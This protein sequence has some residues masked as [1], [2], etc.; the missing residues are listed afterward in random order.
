MISILLPTKERLV[1]LKK[2]VASVIAQ[3]CHDWELCISDNC[4]GPEVENWIRQLGDGRIKYFRQPRLVAVTDNWNSAY[5]LSSGDYIL[6]LGDDDLLRKGCLTKLQNIIEKFDKPEGIYYQ[7]LMVKY[8]GVT[9]PESPPEVLRCGVASF[10]EGIDEPFL[11]PR[12]IRYQA[13]HQAFKFRMSYPFNMQLALMRR[14]FIVEKAEDQIFRS[15]YPDYFAMNFLMLEAN[16]VVGVPENLVT[17]GVTKKSFGYF[18]FNGTSAYGYNYLQEQADNPQPTR[19]NNTST[20]QHLESWL[21]AIG[22]V[23][24]AA[25]NTTL[26]PNLKRFRLLTFAQLA[27]DG[28]SG[29]WYIQGDFRKIMHLDNGYL[30]VKWVTAYRILRAFSVLLPSKV[31]KFAKVT[32]HWFKLRIRETS[33]DESMINIYGNGEM[34]LSADKN[35]TFNIEE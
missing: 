11:V 6:M 33:W 7:G 21:D 35:F 9:S 10:L 3:D 17:V 30:L 28:I 31:V 26:T 18:Y 4:S 20:S 5:S 24:Q 14:D 13:V 32:A 12:E 22:H 1:Y 15:S 23:K 19:L 8:P 16:S 25:S 34:Q 2:A 27:R 29:S